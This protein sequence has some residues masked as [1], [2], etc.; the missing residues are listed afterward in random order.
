MTNLNRRTALQLLGVG[1][2]V[3]AGG[4]PLAHGT[5]ARDSASIAW[6][7]DVPSWDPNQ[8][9]G[10]DAQPL[11][12]MVFDQPVGQNPDL[13]LVPELLE[14]WEL[15]DDAMELRFRV[16][17]DVVFHDGTKMTAEDIRYTFFERIKAGH[18]IDIAN[19]WRRVEDIEVLSPTE[20]VMRFSAP[21][22]TA[23]QWLAFQGG[24]VV[25]K[26]YMEE[27]GLEGFRE[28]PV[29]TGPYRLV[30]YQMNSRM[31]FERHDAY[32]R[33]PA[34][35]KRI[36][37]EVIKES[38]ARVAAIQSGQTDL[39]INV[40]VREA[41]RLGESGDLI[42]ELNPI[43]RV[44][45]LQVRHDLAFADENVRL[46]A[47][48]AIDKQALSKAF[49]GGAAVPLSVMAPPGTPGDVADFEIPYDPEKAK[50]LL[51]ESGFS[52]DNP[53]KLTLAA[54]NGHFPSDFDI[55]RALLQMWKKVGIEAELDVI[56]Y[57]KYFE[58]NRGD[59]LP[60]ATLYSWDNATGDPEIFTGYMLNPEMPFSSWKGDEP[61]PQVLELFKEP[62]YEKRI[63]GYRDLNR[64]ASEM[65]AVMPLLQSVQ[66]LVRKPDLTY[67]KFGNG[68]V[69][70]RTLEW[71]AE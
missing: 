61:G 9:F 71:D 26:H 42:A 44:I 29:G 6:P 45:L 13:D 11:F 23:P 59:K 3:A 10:P 35:L 48:Y 5:E 1:A 65:G 64:R 32:W 15:S 50:A 34:P 68:W 19:T 51:A 22:P 38:S 18:P 27:V 37:I 33:G 58:L 39:T 2:L 67:E 43:T 57:A 20:G 70:G 17:D 25:P 28:K 7:S 12:K 49:Y 31:V 30:E 55:A 60:E 52:P 21:M 36:T 47:H 62:D 8:R 53:V 40:P 41:E 63:A 24:F 69:L 4:V 66:T 56:E 16:R 54:T 46:A 14:E